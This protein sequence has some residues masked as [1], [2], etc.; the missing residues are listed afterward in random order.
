MVE[1]L[2]AGVPACAKG[3]MRLSRR[4]ALT[5]ATAALS[6]PTVARGAAANVLKFIPQAGL[7]ILDP[8]WSSTAVTA[9]HGYYV[10]DTLFGVDAQMRPRPQMAEGYTVSDD[11]L[12][13][14]IRLRQG[15]LFHDGTQVRGV[16][17]AASLRRWSTFDVF[18]QTLATSV[19]GWE[20]PDDR[21]LRIRLTRRFPLLIDALAKPMSVVPF[22]MPQR[23]ARAAHDAQVKEMVGSGPYRFIPEEFIA[24]STAAYRRF[25]QYVPRSEPPSWTSGGKI[26]H[27]DR[28]EWQA[29]PDSATAAAA[30]Q[31]GE[32]DWWEQVLPDYVPLLSKNKSLA[33][34]ISDPTG[35]VGFLRFN[36]IVP[37]FDNVKLRQAVLRAVNQSDYMAAVTG[38]DPSDY[39]ICHSF[40]PC[41]TRYGDLPVTDMAPAAISIEQARKLVAASGYAG[42]KV[43]IINPVDIPTITPFGDVTADLLHR[44]GINVDLQSIDWGTVQQRLRNKGPVAN[45][46]WNIMHSWW[47]GAAIAQPVSNA[48]IRGQGPNGFPGWY[49]S[50]RM[51]NLNSAWLLAEQSGQQDKL[52]SEMESIAFADVPS[53]PLGQFFIRTAVRKTLTGLV[54]GPKPVPWNLRPV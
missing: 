17:C 3:G 54:L 52:V 12:V 38:N 20:S 6:M 42:E 30:M 47:S 14:D 15:L 46:G 34:R 18:G 45:G 32:A 25:E 19:A 10:F 16:D 44:M 49:Q 23:L 22:I 24:G 7:T 11:G 53:I 29:Q 2:T 9:N 48:L 35:L 28:V 50:Q 26:V 37:P 31:A 4:S 21:T 41:G 8:I 1:R 40:F 43:V 33:L 5:L 27:F 51:E 39:R 36:S 13:Y